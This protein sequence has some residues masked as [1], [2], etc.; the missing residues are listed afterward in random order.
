MNCATANGFGL[1]GSI[2]V[3]VFFKLLILIFAF[4]TFIE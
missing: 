4:S 1:K 2:R 3:P